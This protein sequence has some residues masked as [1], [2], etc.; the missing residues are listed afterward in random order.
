MAEPRVDKVTAQRI[1]SDFIRFDPELAQ[2]FH[3]YEP[4]SGFDYP[5]D[6]VFKVDPPRAD[7]AI[8][9]PVAPHHG[10]IRQHFE[11][12]TSST[13]LADFKTR[14]HSTF[15]ISSSI[16]LG[17]HPDGETWAAL[18]VPLEQDGLK[19]KLDGVANATAAKAKLLHAAVAEQLATSVSELIPRDTDGNFANPHQAR[20]LIEDIARAL[21]RVGR[22]EG[23]DMW[24]SLGDMFTRLMG[25]KRTP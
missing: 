11:F 9:I 5:H 3:A 25:S 4:G 13:M 2:S 18:A 15:G 14:L 20:T 21:N 22:E 1:L 23:E 19:G 24:A 10:N 8:I 6:M 12:F 7:Q 16:V 17:S